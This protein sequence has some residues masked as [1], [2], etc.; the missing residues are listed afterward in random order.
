MRIS[1]MRAPSGYYVNSRDGKW[2]Q[3]IDTPASRRCKV[4]DEGGDERDGELIFDS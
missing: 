3:K 4:G 1:I 2:E